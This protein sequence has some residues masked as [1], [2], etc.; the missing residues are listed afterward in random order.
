MANN[1][2]SSPEKS[3]QIFPKRSE[4]ASISESFALNL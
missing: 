2:V 4:F 3:F 1:F